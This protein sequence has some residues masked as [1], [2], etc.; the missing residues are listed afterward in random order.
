[1]KLKK[2]LL[3]LMVL[4]LTAC[5]ANPTP[6][7][8]P[9]I[10]PSLNE[11][12]GYATEDNEQFNQFI[13][14]MFEQT[15]LDSEVNFHQ[16]IKDPANFNFDLSQ[17]Q[18]GFG[19]DYSKESSDKYTQ[20]LANDFK[21]LQSFDYV[22]LSRKQQDLYDTLFFDFDLRLQASDPKFDYYD[23]IFSPMNGL[24]NQIPTVLQ[25]ARLESKYDIERVISIMDS[26]PSLI[27]SA[28]DYAKS[29]IE[30]NTLIT[31]ADDVIESCN[32]ILNDPAKP[33][34]SI[35]IANVNA[36][37]DCS[38]EEKQATITTI[39]EK[40]NTIEESY[41]L[42]IDFFTKN[43]DSVNTQG[44]ASLKYGKEYYG[45]ICQ[46][47]SGF[48]YDI[49][50]LDTLMEDFTQTYLNKMIGI[51]AKHR[52][53]DD[54]LN[55]LDE[56]YFLE[57]NSYEEI[58][59]FAKSQMDQ[60]VP[61]ITDVTVDISDLPESLAT[62]GILA[63]YLYPELDD[64][65]TQT[66]CVNPFNSNLSSLSTYTTVNHESYL[67][68]LY[69]TTYAYQN[70]PGSSVLKVLLSPTANVEGYARYCEYLAL[71]YMNHW[72]EDQVN[73]YTYNQIINGITTIQLD[74]GIHYNGWTLKQASDFL[75]DMGIS[76]NENLIKPLYEQLRCNPA[77][78]QPYEFGNITYMQLREY[79]KECLADRFNEVAFHTALLDA[80][81]TP[82]STLRKS[83][84]NYITKT[85]GN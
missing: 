25:H 9:T 82:L 73:I 29:Q 41:R 55:F 53:E 64:Y 59:D 19:S 17:L 26:I 49:E 7:I 66:I 34:L 43:Y 14:A 50:Q 27:Q 67:G 60:Y 69:Q 70:N 68:H 57:F 72:N 78:F 5:Q 84:D 4:G 48:Y 23:Q 63:Y 42:I 52:D 45:I 47:E 21:T 39:N 12:V 22:S 79:A 71:L 75:N 44:Y 32:D 13:D 76:T 11:S 46:L 15:L 83:V 2:I 56:D 37:P 62:D 3:S 8:E 81:H 6:S 33:I 58:I 28:L 24:H 31:N 35:L 54:F 61:P 65:Q 85:L 38:N 30:L 80:S 77:T 1:M 36:L 51:I 16:F 74:Y 40:Y 18:K 20:R 10:T